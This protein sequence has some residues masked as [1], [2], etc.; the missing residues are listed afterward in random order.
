MDPRQTLRDVL[1]DVIHD[2]TEQASARMHDYFVHKTREVSGLATASQEV[3]GL[4]E[5]ETDDEVLDNQ[6]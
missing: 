6:E 1:Q 4:D 3:E 5:L 2:R